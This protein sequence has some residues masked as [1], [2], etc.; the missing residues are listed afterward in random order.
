MIPAGATIIIER[1]DPFSLEL[2]DDHHHDPLDPW[3]VAKYQRLLMERPEY[4]TDPILVVVRDGQRYIQRGRHRVIANRM[5]GR[6]Q[7][8]AMVYEWQA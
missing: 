6:T 7:M 2:L 1:I 5:A 8:L 3:M 4:D